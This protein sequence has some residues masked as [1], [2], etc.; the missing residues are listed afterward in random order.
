MDDIDFEKVSLYDYMDSISHMPRNFMQK[1]QIIEVTEK[2]RSYL[3]LDKKEPVYYSE[4]IGFDE[5][6]MIVVYT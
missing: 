6:G 3:E 1:L 5:E 2:E 4:L